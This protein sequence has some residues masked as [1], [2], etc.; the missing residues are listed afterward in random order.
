MKWIKEYMK[1]EKKD[2]LFFKRVSMS[3]GEE[4]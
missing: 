2:N 3:K 4:R 1:N